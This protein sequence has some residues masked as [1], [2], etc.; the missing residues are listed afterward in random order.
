MRKITA[1]LVLLCATTLS[2]QNY[3]YDE[4]HV[5]KGLLNG[6]TAFELAFQEAR[7][8]GEPRCAGYI[9]YPNAKTPAPIL[10]VGQYL[11]ADPKDPY[12][13]NLYHLAF[14]E[15]QPDGVNTGKID[16]SY[17]EVEGDYTFKKG[18]WINPDNRRRLPMTDTESRFDKPTWWPGVPAPLTAPKR[19]AYSYKYHFTKDEYGTLQDISVDLFADGKKVGPEIK[20]TYSYP[21]NEEQDL[22][23][24][25]E[26]DINF[27]GIPDLYIFTGF[28]S[29]AQS[30]YAGY[31]WNPVTCQFYRVDT[32]DEI[33]EPDFDEQAKT[34][35]SRAR[36]NQ[37]LY[38]DVYKWKNGKLTKI[39]SK[40]ES[41]FD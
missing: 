39:Y 9:Y 33:A 15:Y 5:F 1:V 18:T 38:L 7:Y 23:W 29:H 30:A 31:V 4:L 3:V 11:E 17:Y 2:A 13:D 28:Q 22:N 16:I 32:F 21:F 19:D 37:Y 20:E 8:N 24:V 12:A 10:I 27:D 36:D 14:E 35:T 6:K 25:R 26:T 40:K 34:I 41:L